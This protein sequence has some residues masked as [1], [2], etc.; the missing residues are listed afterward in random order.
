METNSKSKLHVTTIAEYV[1]SKF[2]D[3]KIGNI[4]AFKTYLERVTKQ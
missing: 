3:A 2:Q 1:K 4:A